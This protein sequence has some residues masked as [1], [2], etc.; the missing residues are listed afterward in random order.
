MATGNFEGMLQQDSYGNVLRPVE[1]LTKKPLIP[2]SS[3]IRVNN[4]A[5]SAKLR[6]GRVVGGTV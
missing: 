4:R 2:S 1:P 5:R 3:E 6:V